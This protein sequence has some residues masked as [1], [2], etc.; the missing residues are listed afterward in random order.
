[1]NSILFWV[2]IASPV[3]GCLA[4]IVALIISRISSK[5]NKSQIKA[6]YDLLDVFV[7]AQNP[8]MI[9]TLRK[10]EQELNLLE[11]QIA[12]AKMD[13]E[14]DHYPFLCQG[15]PAIQIIE[16]SEETNQRKKHLHK[17]LTQRKD[18]VAKKKIIQ[19]YFDKVKK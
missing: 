4:I 5:E 10:Y 16:A 19:S 9:E 7:A 3:I 6:I 14:T 15:S 17:L 13:L 1:M 11:E 8:S 12:E 2:S 18:L